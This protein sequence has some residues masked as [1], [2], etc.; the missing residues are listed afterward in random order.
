MT[1]IPTT[2]GHTLAHET[3][4][5]LCHGDVHAILTYGFAETTAQDVRRI[6]QALGL[7]VVEVFPAREADRPRFLAQGRAKSFDGRRVRVVRSMNP[8][9][10]VAWVVRCL[11]Q[12]DGVCVLR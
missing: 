2:H 8:P 11:V 7:D 12:E 1:A 3:C 6:S 10:D 4:N 9:Q 5:V